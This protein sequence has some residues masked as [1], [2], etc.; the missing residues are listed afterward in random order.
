MSGA[1][2]SGAF[3]EAMDG[4]G[5]WVIPPRKAIGSYVTLMLK[6]SYQIAEYTFQPI[7]DN[8][9]NIHSLE[10]IFDD[11]SKELVHMSHLN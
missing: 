2:C 1:D 3:I 9:N 11:G 8:Y 5:G 4:S 10:I 7:G 6:K